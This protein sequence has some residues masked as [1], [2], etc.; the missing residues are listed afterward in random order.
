MSSRAEGYTTS[1]ETVLE[2]LRTLRDMTCVLVHRGY[3][4]VIKNTRVSAH[5]T[6]GGY[7]HISVLCRILSGVR[8]SHPLSIGLHTL[9]LVWI[10]TG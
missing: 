4:I 6:Y 2:V 5:E 3:S 10:P 1:S 7:G 9:Q 8:P